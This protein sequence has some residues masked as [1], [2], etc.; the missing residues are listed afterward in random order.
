MTRTSFFF[1]S[2]SAKFEKSEREKKREGM[3]TEMRA[4]MGLSPETLVSDIVNA[5]RDYAGDGFDAVE[6]C[7]R[8]EIWAA[9]GADGDSALRQVHACLQSVYMRLLGSVDETFEVFGAAVQDRFLHVPA[10]MLIES[11][12]N[13]G[14]TLEAHAEAAGRRTGA[15]AADGGAADAGADEAELDERLKDL[16][17]RIA[18]V[19]AAHM[20]ISPLRTT[21][22]ALMST[23]PMFDRCECKQRGAL[24][25]AI[26]HRYSPS[27]AVSRKYPTC[28]QRTTQSQCVRRSNTTGNRS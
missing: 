23:M 12:L 27:D 3:A 2:R 14:R 8:K 17:C 26:I 15:D 19:S 6:D 13:A 16:R 10:E 7:M 11:G 22:V 28:C 21:V 9:G 1:L 24:L 4:R 25:P 18:M 20:H 5:V